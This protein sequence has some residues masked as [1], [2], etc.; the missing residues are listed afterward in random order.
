MHPEHWS[1]KKA[2]SREFQIFATGSHLH[3]KNELQGDEDGVVAVSAISDDDGDDDG[4]D[5]DDDNDEN[6]ND[7]DNDDGTNRTAL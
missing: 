4:D 5:D 3:S 7:Y 6:D 1:T 2:V